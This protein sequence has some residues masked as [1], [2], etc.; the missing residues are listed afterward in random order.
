[1]DRRVCLVLTLML[2]ASAC[3]NGSSSA[4]P[5]PAQPPSLEP[6]FRGSMEIS[7][8]RVRPGEQVA[9]RL[10]DQGTFGVAFSLE[11]WTDAEWRVR[12]YLTSDGGALGW[13]PGWWSIEDSE[14]RGWRDI[15][16][17][18]GL[19]PHHLVIPDDIPTGSYRLCTA[20]SVNKA[21]AL[22]TIIP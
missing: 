7:P 18:G 3:G 4:E 5:Q 20:N 12:Y 22:V 16:V 6:R 10:P 14:G 11:A 15:G 1:M 17:A 19:P 2:A 8:E 9:V 13:T 21:C